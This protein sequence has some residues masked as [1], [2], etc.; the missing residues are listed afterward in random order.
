[1]KKTSIY[2][3]DVDRE[4]LCRLAE[5]EGKSQALIIREALAVYDA[6]RPDR[7]FEILNM[8]LEPGARGFPHFDDPQDF[9]DWID[10]E[11]LKGMGEDSFGDVPPR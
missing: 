1:M 6:S 8:R 2:L 7:N 4:R 5:R 11:G 10:T 9:Q 3:D